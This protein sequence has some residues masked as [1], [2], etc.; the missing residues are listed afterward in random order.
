MRISSWLLAGMLSAAAGSSRAEEAVVEHFVMPMALVERNLNGSGSSNL[1][2]MAQGVYNGLLAPTNGFV[3]EQSGYFQITVYSDRSF[4]GRM[5][6]AGG[7]TPLRG[8][9][10]LQGLA[11]FSV[12]WR[13]WDDCLCFYELRL[14]WNV[15][16]ELLPGT[17]IIQGTAENVKYGWNTELFGLKGRS[18]NDGTAPEKGRYTMRLPG[19]SDPAVAPGGEGYGVVKVDSLGN[20]T[21]T[22]ALADGFKYCRTAVLSTNGWWPFY[23]SLNDGRGAVIGWLNFSNAP[24]SDI[25]GD[26]L[27]ARP[28]NDER[29]YYPSGYIGVSAARGAR[30]V[31]PL[32]GALALSWSNGVFRLSGGNLSAPVTNSVTLNSSGLTDNG[33]TITNVTFSLDRGTGVFRGKFRHPIS[34][35]GT[36]YA[37]ALNQLED[38]GAGYFLGSSQGGLV[39]LEAVP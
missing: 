15:T 27:W 21:A 23:I 18:R 31:A 35:K 19:S 16:L 26:L 32:S 3:P 20:V 33:G 9:F 24:T 25:A 2:P 13:S 5:N 11:R 17:N 12:S 6:V 4:S 36:S 8:R 39:R 34:G 38:I 37:G 10:A 29:Q 30:Y 14:V 22:G 1:F 7:S 28:H